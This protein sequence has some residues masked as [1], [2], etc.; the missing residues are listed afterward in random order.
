LELKESETTS[1]PFMVLVVQIVTISPDFL[2]QID[3]IQ[4]L[5]QIPNF[6][7]CEQLRTMA[8]TLLGTFETN[9]LLVDLLP[10]ADCPYSSEYFTLFASRLKNPEDG[11]F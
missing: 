1:I 9:S 10:S 11:F 8:V 3:S 7:E 5:L 2:A 4:T 6:H